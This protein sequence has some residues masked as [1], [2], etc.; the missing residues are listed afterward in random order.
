[1]SYNETY[2]VEGRAERRRGVPE[3]V[4]GGGEVV[5]MVCV[6]RHIFFITPVRVSPERQ[7]ALPPTM[8]P[9]PFT[10]TANHDSYGG[11][12]GQ[13]TDLCKH[14]QQPLAPVER[15]RCPERLQERCG[16]RQNL[17]G[18]R[19]ESWLVALKSAILG[20]YL[21]AGPAAHLAARALSHHD[22]LPPGSEGVSPPRPCELV[23]GTIVASCCSALCTVPRPHRR[24]V[25]RSVS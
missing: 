3:S 9:A 5:G 4:D 6:H 20:L 7:I 10:A 21:E 22:E 11:V 15:A 8:S 12:V 1:M 25:R 19:Q 16:A 23:E 24:R 14:L 13:N 2:C 17:R 18:N